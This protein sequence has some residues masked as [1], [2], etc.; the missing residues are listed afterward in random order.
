VRID[1]ALDVNPW[2]SATLPKAKGRIPQATHSTRAKKAGAIGKQG[3]SDVSSRERDG[4][5]EA[6]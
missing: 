2:F 6:S 1:G 3:G 5:G 4:F